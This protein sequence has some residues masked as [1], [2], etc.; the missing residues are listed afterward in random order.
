MMVTDIS[1]DGRYRL[2]SHIDRSQMSR[3][4]IFLLSLADRQARKLI[5]TR[6]R[7]T[8]ARFSPDGQ[9]VA[10][11]SDESGRPEVYVAGVGTPDSRLPLTSGGGSHPTWR[12]DGRELFYLDLQ[13]RLIAVPLGP[14]PAFQPDT[15]RVLFQTELPQVSQSAAGADYAVTADGSRVI[16]KTPAQRPDQSPITV[17]LNSDGNARDSELDGNREEGGV[18]PCLCRARLRVDE[19][20]R[21]EPAAAGAGSTL[22]TPPGL[23]STTRYRKPSGPTRT[24]RIR[25]RSDVA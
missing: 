13:G 17:F 15:P 6:Y 2:Y 25:W 8:Q 23:A 16:I 4:D 12:R 24:S 9:W 10:Y 18:G 5:Q 14:G 20:Y 7:E 19:S 11:S 21:P 3:S 1:R 22:S